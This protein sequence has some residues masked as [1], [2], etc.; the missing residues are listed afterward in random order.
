MPGMMTQSP[1]C[2]PVSITP[3]ASSGKG[4]AGSGGNCLF[5]IN[6]AISGLLIAKGVIL[7]GVEGP[8]YLGSVFRPA[9]AG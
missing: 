4:V 7:S 8:S 2:R 6:V 3:V 5:V 9:A 1:C